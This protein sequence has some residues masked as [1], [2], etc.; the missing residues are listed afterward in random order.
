MMS[1]TATGKPNK[2][3][4]AR[5]SE[6]PC[7]CRRAASGSCHAQ[8]WICGSRKAIRARQAS[9]TSC[10]VTSPSANLLVRS[11]ALSVQRLESALPC[12]VVMIAPAI[13]SAGPIR[14]QGGQPCKRADQPAWMCSE[15]GDH[16]IFIF[17]DDERFGDWRLI[18]RHKLEHTWII[19]VF[20]LHNQDVGIG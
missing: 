1:L 15:R 11:V 4:L 18:D 20:F 9:S 2:G 7:N 5:R 13:I 16:R 6:S 14:H 17:L 3:R 8:A 10:A 19:L 12:I